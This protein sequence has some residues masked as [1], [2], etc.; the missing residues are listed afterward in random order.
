MRS[1]KSKEVL[2][3]F[4]EFK[5]LVQNQTGRRIRVLRSDNGGEYTSKE[6]NEFY[7]YEGVKRHL[8]VPYTQQ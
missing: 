1:K 5:A 4:Q 2:K 3:R 7:A 6:F 8:T